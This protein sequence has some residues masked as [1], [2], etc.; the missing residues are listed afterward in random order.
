MSSATVNPRDHGGFN[1]IARLLFAISVRAVAWQMTDQV[2]A[3]AGL[4][5]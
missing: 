1:R 2:I 5:R 3:A 4:E